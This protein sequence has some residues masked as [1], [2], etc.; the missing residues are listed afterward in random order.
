MKMAFRNVLFFLTSSCFATQL[1]VETEDFLRGFS[2]TFTSIAHLSI[3]EQRNTI[4]EMFR[5][6]EELLE[7]IASTEDRIVSGRNGPI[8]IRIFSPKKGD[9]LSVIVYFHRGGWVYGSVE[10]SEMICRK[11][12]NK[13]GAHVVAVEYRLSP[14]HQFPIPLQDCYDTVKWVVSNAASFNGNPGKVILCGESAGGNLAAATA[15]MI[16]DRNEFSVAAELLIYPILTSDLNRGHYD[17]SP[18]K[19]LLSYGNMEFFIQSYLS[20]SEMGKEPYAFPLNSKNFSELPSTLIVTA[21]HDA[22]KHEGK[23]YAE[24]LRLAGVSVQSKC[25]PGVIHGFLDLPLA[26][27][28]QSQA[29][30]DIESWVKSL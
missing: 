15:L 12:A 3:P 9:G 29:L 25:Y 18:D 28:I 14:E 13:V 6:P 4:K 21:E 8:N 23:Q 19:S 11:M 22:L 24:N 7:P 10:E 17:E 27:E 26:F 1:D 20:S 5:I 30:E 2:E 16:R